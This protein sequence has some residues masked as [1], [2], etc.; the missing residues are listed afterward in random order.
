M[1][2]YKELSKFIIENIGGKDNVIS[3]THCVTRLRFK[4]HD[5]SKANKAKLQQ[6]DGIVSVVEKAGQFQVVI[7]NH[8]SEV[9][10]EIMKDVSLETIAKASKNDTIK[11]S[12]FNRF[13]SLVS[14]IFTPLLGLLCASGIIKGSL[15]FISSLGL[16]ESTSSTYTL[17][18]SMGDA[19]FYFFPVVLGCSAAEKFGLN[20]YVGIILGAILVHPNMAALRSGDVLFSLFSGTPFESNVTTTLFGL[21]VILMNYANSVIPIVFAAYLGSKVEAI[22]KQYVPS[23]IKMFTVPAITILVTSI[24]TLMLIGPL[25]TWI[26]QFIG[27]SLVTIRNISPILSGALVGGFWQFIVILGLNQGLFPIIVTNLMTIGYD[28]VFAPMSIVCFSTFAVVLAIYFKTKNK[29]LKN[30]ALPAAISSFFGISE[31]SLYGITIPLKK[32]FII[33]SIASAIGGVVMALFDSKGYTMGGMGLFAFP[34]FINP[35]AGFDMGFYGVIIAAIV[36]CFVG[37]TLTW[38]FGFKDEDYLKLDGVKSERKEGIS[39]QTPVSGK[40][41]S[42]KEVNDDVFS[43]ELIGKGIAIIPNDG[44]IYSPAAGV[45]KSLFST[46]HAIGIMTDSNVEVLIHIGIDTVQME[47]KGFT[48][49]VKQGDQVEE[50]TLL[51]SFDQALIKENGYED[52]VIIVVTNANDFEEIECSTKDNVMINDCLL[53]II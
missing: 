31:P 2:S 49:H 1:K 17:L 23:V 3:L 13:V 28:S 33:T 9:Y 18:F 52:V 14:G 30:I 6:N 19:M 39:I 42:L 46:G 38:L 47:G 8:V 43:E 22:T 21:P 32:P 53:T 45:V 34:S 15:V 29:K 24:I 51:I 36:A 44:N 41:V 27:W 20:K 50:G 37:F 4:L 40:L 35:K 48:K 11:E 16:M 12:I 5:Q 25:A 7:G 10:D 26:S